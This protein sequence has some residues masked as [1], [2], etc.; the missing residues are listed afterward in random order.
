MISPAMV[1]IANDAK[2]TPR[3][4]SNRSGRLDQAERSRLERV[5][6][7]LAPADVAPRQRADEGKV[8]LDQA[9]TAGDLEPILAVAAAMDGRDGRRRRHGIRVYD[10]RG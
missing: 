1:G 6:E 5:L 2:A 3:R 8:L 4:P 9:M 7:V 10:I